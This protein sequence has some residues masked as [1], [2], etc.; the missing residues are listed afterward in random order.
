MEEIFLHLMLAWIVAVVLA[1]PFGYIFVKCFL[2][3]RKEYGVNIWTNPRAIFSLMI[4]GTVEGVE[5]DAGKK[6][7][8]KARISVLWWN[9]ILFPLVVYWTYVIFSF[10]G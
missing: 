9:I 6:I 10:L 1:A 5:D 2:S 8:R 3:I 4:N 7:L